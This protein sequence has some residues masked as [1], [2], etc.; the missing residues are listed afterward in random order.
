MNP[1]YYQL[2]SLEG[3]NVN[4]FLS[5]L[6]EKT[7][8]ELVLSGKFEKT[9]YKRKLD[10]YN[11]G[12]NIKLKTLTGVVEVDEDDENSLYS[13]SLGRLTSYYYLRHTTSR[14][15]ARQMSQ[16]LKSSELLNLL[17]EASEFSELPVRHNEDQEN[18]ILAG[19]VPLQASIQV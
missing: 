18:E 3:E 6:V 8:G 13:T 7:L 15:F 19:Q 16:G 14:H 12:F 17:C 4:N 11:N 10:F 1:N 2:E 9:S 5:E